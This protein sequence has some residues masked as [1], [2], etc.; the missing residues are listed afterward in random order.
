M[1]ALESS[2]HLKAALLAENSLRSQD[3]AALDL[4]TAVSGILQKQVDRQHSEKESKDRILE[5]YKRQL[6]ETQLARA[7]D[8]QLRIEETQSASRTSVTKDVQ[9]NSLTKDDQEN[10]GNKGTPNG[11]SSFGWAFIRKKFF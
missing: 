6:E 1:D 10:N 7:K 3:K 8:L 4:S 2:W 5:E 11:S 9:E